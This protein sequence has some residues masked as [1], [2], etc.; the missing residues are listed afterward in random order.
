[1]GGNDDPENLIELTIEDHAEAHRI[2][3]EKYGLWQ[4]YLAWKGL[5]KLLTTD[6]CRL[7]S[8]KEGSKK[9]GKNACLKRWG[10]HIKFKDDPDFIPYHKRFFGYDKNVDGRKIRT[11]RYWFNN[12][13]LEGQ[14]S[15]EEYPENWVRGRLKSVMKKTNPYVSL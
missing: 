2:L 8:I 1:M 4:D 5:L 7:L 14:F 15:L 9:G 6:E 12:G 11:K 13:V 10:D 3:Y